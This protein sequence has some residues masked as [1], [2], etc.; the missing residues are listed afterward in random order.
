MSACV[1]ACI[2]VCTCIYVCTCAC[3]H[4]HVCTCVESSYMYF[5]ICMPRHANVPV[6]FEEISIR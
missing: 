3:A 6:D 4:M 1:H 2:G 5:Y